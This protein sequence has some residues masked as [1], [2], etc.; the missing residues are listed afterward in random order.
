MHAERLWVGALNGEEIYP[1]FNNGKGYWGVLY[2]TKTIESNVSQF[3]LIRTPDQGL[4]IGMHDTAIRYLLHFTFEQR[5]G[6]VDWVNNSVP[7]QDEISGL[8][9]HLEFRACHFLF[10]HPASQV[11]LSPIVV[12]PYDGDWHAGLDVYKQWRATWFGTPKTPRLGF[13]RPFLAATPDRWRRTG[14]RVPYREIVR[15]GE[16]CAENGVSAIQLVAWNRGGQDGGDPSLDTDPALGTWQDL[17]D[18]IATIQTKGVKMIL[19]GKPVFADMSTDYYK[20]E[21]YKYEA[22]D[23]WG[24]K[25]E[26]NGYSYTTP[27]ATRRH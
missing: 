4:Y 16:E 24:N 26:S 17:Y 7:Q 9:V 11:R 23:M 27:N 3:C 6:N 13:G 8:P 1:C 5:P 15:Y 2:P 22:V 10:A 21:L 20:K 14:Y 19:F 12:H 18:A 25:Y